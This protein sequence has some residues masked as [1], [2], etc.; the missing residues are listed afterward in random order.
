MRSK[1]FKSICAI[2]LTSSLVSCNKYAVSVNNKVVYMPPHL[3]NDFAISD[4]HLRTCVEQTISDNHI[5]AA[6]DLK[7]LNC[8]NAGIVNLSGLDIFYAIEQINL[9]E[10]AISS[11]TP[12]SKLSALHSVILRKN[13]L[14][15][16]EP[17][18][19]LLHLRDL[20]ISENEKLACGDLKQL[21]N[22]FH[23]GELNATL[24]AQCTDKK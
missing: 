13:Q 21:V 15:S 17:L 2:L 6:G 16:A 7:Q 11:I 9:A 12:L 10:N 1:H 5:T 3:F 23:S 14:T 18:L 8:S 24:P 19:H 4:V 20:D 22:N